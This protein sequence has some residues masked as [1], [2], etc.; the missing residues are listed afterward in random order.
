MKKVTKINYVIFFSNYPNTP[1][2]VEHVNDGRVN[3]ANV[4]VV[5][6]CE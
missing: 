1:G 2:S 4:V 5:A 6:Y 3:V